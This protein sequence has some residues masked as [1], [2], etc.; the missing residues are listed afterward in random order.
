MMWILLSRLEVLGCGQCGGRLH[1][2]S[3]AVRDATPPGA[4]GRRHSDTGGRLFLVRHHMKVLSAQNV[5]VR[6]VLG[7]GA[8]ALRSITVA[9]HAWC[10]GLALLFQDTKLES[11]GNRVPTQFSTSAT[12]QAFR[13]TRVL[14]L[15]H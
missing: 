8:A 10:S 14:Q 2:A 11:T 13:P 3:V 9:S 4:K 12:S 15:S 1:Q 5:I 7:C 6:T